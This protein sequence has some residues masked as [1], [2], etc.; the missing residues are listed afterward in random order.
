MAL[1]SGFNLIRALCALHAVLGYLLI[2]NPQR[3]AN[4]NTIVV[5][6]QA[7]GVV[8]NSPGSVLWE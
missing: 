6:G 8:R 5:L 3:L 4:M 7:I 2:K 1:I